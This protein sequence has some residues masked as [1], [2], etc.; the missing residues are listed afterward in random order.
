[1]MLHQTIKLFCTVKETVKKKRPP[2][3]WSKN[4]F[5]NNM[6]DK[7][8]ILKKKKNSYSSSKTNN[9]IKKW[10]EDLNRYYSIKTY[11]GSIES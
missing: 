1:M 8:L 2:T 4:I 6:S 3:K 7:G 10:A 5:A 9:L 11:R